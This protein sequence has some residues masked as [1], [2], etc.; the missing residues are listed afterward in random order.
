[1]AGPSKSDRLSP[2]LMFAFREAHREKDARKQIDLRDESGVRILAGRRTIRGSITES[3]LRAQLAIDLTALMNTV[4]LHTTL[5]LAPFPDVRVSIL[6]FGIPEISNRTID[7]YRTADIV[8]EI[9]T[10]LLTYE[11]RLI[12]NTIQVARDETIDESTLGIRFIVTGEMACD[13]VAVPV[14]FVAD[15]EIDTGKVLLTGR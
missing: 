9:E 7:E 14:H 2:P 4:N 13:P 15:L 12:P 5:D 8:T 6:N 10:A 1:M 11:P 3:Q